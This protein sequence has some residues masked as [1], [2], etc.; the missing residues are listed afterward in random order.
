MVS[1]LTSRWLDP[2]VNYH[3]MMI[4]VLAVNGWVVGGFGARA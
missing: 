3:V 2:V 4:L 1:T